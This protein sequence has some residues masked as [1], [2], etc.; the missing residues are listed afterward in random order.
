MSEFYAQPNPP[1]PEEL[2]AQQSERLEAAKRE[3]FRNENSGLRQVIGEL[4]DRLHEQDVEPDVT[5]LTHPVHYNMG[6]VHKYATLNKRVFRS[7]RAHEFESGWLVSTRKQNVT[8][9]LV[10]TPDKEL[11]VAQPSNLEPGKRP[12][13]MPPKQSKREPSDASP[14][15]AVVWGRVKWQEPARISAANGKV[16]YD[17]EANR[18]PLLP[19]FL[20]DLDQ[21]QLNKEIRPQEVPYASRELFKEVVV[22]ELTHDLRENGRRLLG[23]E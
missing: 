14:Q 8:R 22:D 23:L 21:D 12:K 11:W 16:V 18:H 13:T 19:D 2:I 1:T 10:L 20:R 15:R 6:K 3:N 7:G 5:L 9:L 4:A 17:I